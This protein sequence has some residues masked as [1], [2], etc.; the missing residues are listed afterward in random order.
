MAVNCN[1][2]KDPA[3]DW[4]NSQSEFW[5]GLLS[6]Q[7]YIFD[8]GIHVEHAH[9]DVCNGDLHAALILSRIIY[10]QGK[11]PITR[12]P[13]L[14]T[15]RDGH[16]WLAR[17][18]KDWWEECRVDAKTARVAIDW[19]VDLGVVVKAM[20]SIDGAPQKHYRINKSRLRELEMTC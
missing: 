17:H 14:K 5:R 11:N 10:W 6:A 15:E 13:R 3:L 1:S 18:H 16:L 12:K 8:T 20:Y 7:D 4:F 9:I 19:L 2:K